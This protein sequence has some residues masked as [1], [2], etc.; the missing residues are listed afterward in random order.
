MRFVTER[1]QAPI[2]ADE[3]VLSPADALQVIKRGAADLITL[4]LA[5]SGGIRNSVIILEAARAAGLGCNLGS[6]H[7][8][9]VGTAALLHFAAAYPEVGEVIGY[10]D[11]RERFV[12][13]VIEEDLRI[14]SGSVHLPEGLGFGVTLDPQALG[15]FAIQH[16]ELRAR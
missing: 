9:G 13:D 10:G 5:K 12:G 2:A 6:K 11:A 7:T 14:E 1:A 15:R 4:K 8:L 3:S 16:H